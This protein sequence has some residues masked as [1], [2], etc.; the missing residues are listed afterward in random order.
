M[1]TGAED[2][3]A[4]NSQISYISPL[5]G[6]IPTPTTIR[7]S[8]S[9]SSGSSSTK[10]VQLRNR[11]MGVRFVSPVKSKSPE[12]SLEISDSSDQ[13][14]SQ[15]KISNHT[16]QDSNSG[17]AVVRLDAPSKIV[18]FVDLTNTAEDEHQSVPP[19]RLENSF[20]S[21]SSGKLPLDLPPLLEVEPAISS[22]FLSLTQHQN[23]DSK[24]SVVSMTGPTFVQTKLNVFTRPVD[25]KANSNAAAT[26]RS[27]TESARSTGILLSLEE[28]VT[29]ARVVPLELLK[30]GRNKKTGSIRRDEPVTKESE[31]CQKATDTEERGETSYE[32][33]LV[34]SSENHQENITRAQAHECEENIDENRGY[35]DDGSENDTPPT[36]PTTCARLMP[37]DAVKLKRSGRDDQIAKEGDTIPSTSPSPVARVESLESEDLN[38]A[39]ARATNAEVIDLTHSVDSQSP[40]SKSPTFMPTVSTPQ[41][42]NFQNLSDCLHQS[43]EQSTAAC[44]EGSS[45]HHKGQGS[46]VRNADSAENILPSFPKLGSPKM[47]DALYR[48]EPSQRVIQD[49][50]DGIGV[51]RRQLLP[52]LTFL[53]DPF[54]TPSSSQTSSSSAGNNCSISSFLQAPSS[55]RLKLSTGKVGDEGEAQT[56]TSS[57]TAT[58]A[59]AASCKS[60]RVLPAFLRPSSRLSTSEPGNNFSK[61]YDN[62]GR[63]GYPRGLVDA[64]VAGNGACVCGYSETVRVPMCRQ[65]R[66]T[67]I[68]LNRSGL[69]GRLSKL[70]LSS[71]EI[72]QVHIHYFTRTCTCTCAMPCIHTCTCTHVHTYMY[73]YTHLHVDTVQALYYMYV[74]M[75]T[76]A[77]VISVVM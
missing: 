65:C 76:V 35:C 15:L 20:Q 1:P 34:E 10:A 68:S 6:P 58:P 8:H 30:L 74:S 29:C 59:A 75:G 5:S 56:T 25:N 18:Q 62:R 54:N 14:D 4:N 57:I 22:S 41:S 72:S 52:S 38:M 2:L 73:V 19:G 69:F 36:S 17:S 12:E 60:K 70:D 13:N 11:S 37:V 26:V 77:M 23:G 31:A 3:T 50:K 27:I 32:S 44:T 39:E 51:K 61:S 33:K 42:G 46:G 40:S 45:D 28:S 9:Y 66:S 43:T 16:T 71:P 21:W 67:V 48:R 64:G 55:K 49:G 24:S 7:R 53:N 63:D 47:T